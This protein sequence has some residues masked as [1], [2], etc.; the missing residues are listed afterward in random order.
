MPRRSSRIRSLSEA[1]SNGSEAVV[2]TKT[3][4]QS[5]K[6]T[7]AGGKAKKRSAESGGKGGKGSTKKSKTGN[8]SPSSDREEMAARGAWVLNRKEE[9]LR[10]SLKLKNALTPMS[11]KG[12]ETDEEEDEDDDHEDSDDETA[13]ARVEK[14]ATVVSK[15]T[16]N[17]ETDEQRTCA[18]EGPLESP[19]ELSKLDR[20]LSKAGVALEIG[21]A[22]KTG[23]GNKMNLFTL[24]KVQRLQAPLIAPSTLTPGDDHSD[25]SIGNILSQ[26]LM[27][28][29]NLYDTSA[30]GSGRGQSSAVD[31]RKK[32]FE[33][34]TPHMTDE[35]K[36]DLELIKMRSFIDPKRFYKKSDGKRKLPTEFQLGTVIEGAGEYKSSRL[37]KKQRRAN[38]AEELYSDKR[39][40]KYTRRVFDAVN[41]KRGGPKKHPHNK[42][43]K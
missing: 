24:S 11:E 8:E 33:F 14:V 26:Q 29:S 23:S 34:K 25:R 9:N 35:I 39:A 36:R 16:V 4:T 28:K 7:A 42:Y 13:P 27:K 17:E 41:S 3:T 43:R 21:G 5:K 12:N 30:E 38:I 37:T 32:F 6:S 15:K 22:R 20:L 40:R 19:T 18:A 1:S 10:P 2:K 31:T